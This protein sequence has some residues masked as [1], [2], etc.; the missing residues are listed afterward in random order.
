MAKKNGNHDLC[1]GQIAR[2]GKETTV[3]F[4]IP[5]KTNQQLPQ[6]VPLYCK[7][8]HRLAACRAQSK[9]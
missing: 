7:C 5:L 2:Y 4:I 6:R 9:V 3:D 1:T 8:A